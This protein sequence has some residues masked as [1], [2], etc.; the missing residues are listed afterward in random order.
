MALGE[1]L[2]TDIIEKP[3]IG[4]G[5]SSRHRRRDG[6]RLW[7]SDSGSYGTAG[8]REIIC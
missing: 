8:L 3:W 4:N 1:Q 6:L 7:L 2:V 5:N